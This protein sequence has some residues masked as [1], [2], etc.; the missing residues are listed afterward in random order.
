L[1]VNALTEPLVAGTS[2]MFEVTE[3]SIAF[4]V[5]TRGCVRPCGHNVRKPSGPGG[6]TVAFNTYDWADAGA[7]QPPLATLTSFC[8]LNGG[9]PGGLRESST[10]HGVKLNSDNPPASGNAKYPLTSITRSESFVTKT[11]TEP[12][13]PAG[14]IAAFAVTAPVGA[15]SVETT[16]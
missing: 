13:A 1:A 9:V 3:P 15:F 10:R 2:A 7:P 5:E 6:T 11:E 12:L 4:S 8:P 16:G 14:T